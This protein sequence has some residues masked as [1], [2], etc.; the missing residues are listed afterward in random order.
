MAPEWSTPTWDR[1]HY[2]KQLRNLRAHFPDHQILVLENSELSEHHTTTMTRVLRFLAVSPD[3]IAASR[4]GLQRQLRGERGLSS[5]ALLRCY[6][7]R[8]NSKLKQLLTDMGVPH[9]WSWLDR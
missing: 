4:G 2:E 7:R 8:S 6:F 9:S 1:G 3:T 5:R